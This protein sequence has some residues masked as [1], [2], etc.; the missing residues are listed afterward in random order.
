MNNSVFSANQFED[1]I[2]EI[3]KDVDITKYKNKKIIYNDKNKDLVNFSILN[4]FFNLM[5]EKTIKNEIKLKSIIRSDKEVKTGLI[6][7]L[8]DLFSKR[9]V[10]VINLSLISLVMWAYAPIVAIRL[11]WMFLP[12]VMM[13]NLSCLVI[14]LIFPLAVAYFM[15]KEKVSSHCIPLDVVSYIKKNS[16][17]KYVVDGVNR[18][19][20]IYNMVKTENEDTN[21]KLLV[22]IIEIEESY[23]KKQGLSTNTVFEIIRKQ[24][25]SLEEFLSEKEIEKTKKKIVELENYKEIL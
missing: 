11:S 2:C 1:L 25:I 18:V 20:F 13:F 4:G 19:D 22:K 12:N 3:N 14:G 10:D 21:E 9:R 7:G 24:K 23:W 15:F 8:K 16:K 5:S 6:A 17:E